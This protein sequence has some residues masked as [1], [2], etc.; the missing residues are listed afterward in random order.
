MSNID[1]AAA[2]TV[3]AA[4]SRTDGD[5]EV[6]AAVAPA[7]A[8][9]E[10][11]DDMKKK[12]KSNIDVK[13]TEDDK[14]KKLNEKAVSLYRYIEVYEETKTLNKQ[15]CLPSFTKPWNSNN[16]EDQWTS[17]HYF[18][19][20]TAA[21]DAGGNEKRCGV[22]LTSYQFDQMLVDIKKSNLAEPKLEVVSTS[23]TNQSSQSSNPDNLYFKLHKPK[24]KNISL[25]SEVERPKVECSEE[26]KEKQ[27]VED[28]LRSLQKKRFKDCN[29][30]EQ[31]MN[32]LIPTLYRFT[33]EDL[34]KRKLEHVMDYSKKYWDNKLNQAIV[35][36][37]ETC[38]Q[39]SG[40]A[41]DKDQ[42]ELVLGLGHVR[43]LY[44]LN[45]KKTDEEERK[46]IV[47]SPLIEILVDAKYEDDVVSISPI[48]NTRVKWSIKAKSALVRRGNR[49]VVSKLNDL[50]A[51]ADSAKIM[52][53]EPSTYGNFLA[54]ASKMSPFGEVVDNNQDSIQAFKD[55][56][57]ALI[58][59][60][61]W[62]LFVRRKRSNIRSR[63]AHA[64]AEALQVR[65]MKMS[66]PLRALVEGLH[67]SKA[68]AS[69]S[70][71][72]HDVSGTTNPLRASN[73]QANII[74]KVLNKRNV[75]TTVQGPP[76]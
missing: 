33:R 62:C 74:R 27:K 68:M 58:L 10:I 35:K 7:G 4:V 46:E 38:H 37:Y 2:T 48:R 18:Y 9:L 32:A 75:V 72:H 11:E 45:K 3:A 60:S 34:I 52:P 51:K 53:G 54:Q 66:P 55:N 17:N 26:E 15:T 67:S 76:G 1:N 6:N 50:V 12:L 49:T 57:D 44:V 65:R 24:V 73:A 8:A 13:E 70:K 19:E 31:V 40:G 69:D 28:T 29:T 20:D 63:D 14:E 47:N 23:T 61:A 39:Y 30:L 42:Y 16:D 36:A 64:I 5:K 56:P 25:R 41:I 71:D 21:K 59:N 43:Q 22:F